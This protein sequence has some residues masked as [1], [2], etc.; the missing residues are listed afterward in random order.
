MK[1]LRFISTLA[2]LALAAAVT[3]GSIYVTASAAAQQD[4]TEFDVVTPETAPTPQDAGGAIIPD[5]Q[6]AFDKFDPA[7]DKSKI[8]RDRQN[9]VI[10]DEN[11]GFS[12]RLSSLSN[13]DGAAV[14]VANVQVTL[15][16]HG[17]EI[18][19]TKTD[20]D[21]RF[22]FTGLPEGVVA[23]WA[24]GE[25]SLLLFSFVLFANSTTI[26]ENEGLL[27]SHVE[28][29]MNSAVA[30]GV[31]ITIVKE[32]IAPFL[33]TE[34]KR[35]VNEITTDEQ[36][37][38]FGSN[39]TSTTLRHHSVRLHD[40]GNL[41]GEINVLDERTGRLREV[42]DMAVH[43]IR[44]GVRVAS[45][46][47]SNDGSF[48]AVGLT[49]GVYSVVAVGQDG[50]LVSCVDIVG[51]N[52]NNTAEDRGDVEFKPVSTIAASLDF[53]GCPVRPGNIQAYMQ[54]H[55]GG[56]SGIA[57]AAMPAGSPVPG[58]GSGYAGG[59]GGGF[60]G[61]GGG[62]GIGG[63]GGLGGLLAGGLAGA[64]GY[65]AGRNSNNTPASPGL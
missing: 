58:S 12:G 31:D 17:S 60:S 43:F 50:I 23:V 1:T 35:F 32:L 29:G 22:S 41:V 5:V 3:V 47:V 63:G 8:L 4:S 65:L 19:V 46:D 20:T 56:S 36:D 21:G 53:D 10:L 13:S 45:A 28:L 51:A 61:G 33:I 24:E 39:E 52:Y 57:G 11:G 15:L 14:S 16:H 44:S 18:G 2:L 64:A 27:A 62:G 54:S 30:S 9:H 34:E 48:V 7:L 49:P 25:N 55:G 26:A 37:F 59:S 38:S 42:L 6:A 40:N